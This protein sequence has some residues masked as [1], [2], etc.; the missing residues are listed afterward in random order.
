MAKIKRPELWGEARVE[1][2]PEEWE[3]LIAQRQFAGLS[4]MQVAH[5]IGIKQP[6]TVSHWERGVN[7]PIESHFKGYLRV[8]GWNDELEY[9]VAP[10]KIDAL[11]G[12]GD[13][14]KNARWREVSQYKPLA[15]FTPVEIG[16]LGDDVKIV[17]QAYHDKAFARHLPI[18]R[19]LMWFLGWYVAEGTMSRHQVSL[20]IGRKDGAFVA[21]LK[22]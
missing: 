20:N 7:R 9:E 16:Q 8:I 13:S 6:I 11:L 21:E 15:D 5:T 4:Q 3:K 22:G 19:E 1:L 10:S 14:S 18:T 17:P 12:Q 2:G